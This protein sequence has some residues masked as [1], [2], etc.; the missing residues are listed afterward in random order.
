MRLWLYRDIASETFSFDSSKE[1]SRRAYIQVVRGKLEIE[2]SQTK[3]FIIKTSDG[4]M[5]CVESS[6]TLKGLD[7]SN[8]VL[9]FDLP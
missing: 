5:C 8:E 6:F 2:S 9:I 7:S 4:V 1:N 3:P